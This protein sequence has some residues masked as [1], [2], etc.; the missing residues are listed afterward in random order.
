MDTQYALA[1]GGDESGGPI[2][3]SLAEASERAVGEVGE[4]GGVLILRVDLDDRGETIGKFTPLARVCR[5]DARGR[6]DWS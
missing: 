2:F 3:D 5:V 4:H 6:I 1:L